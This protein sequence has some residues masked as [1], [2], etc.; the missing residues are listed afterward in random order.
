MHAIVNPPALPS[1]QHLLDLFYQPPPF[2]YIEVHIQLFQQRLS[3]KSVKPYA[4]MPIGIV[5]S[6]SFVFLD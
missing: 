3:H 1:P 5:S 4:T 6:K 2:P